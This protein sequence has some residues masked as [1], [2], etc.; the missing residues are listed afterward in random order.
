MNCI[1]SYRALKADAFQIKVYP[2]VLVYKTPAAEYLKRTPCHPITGILENSLCDILRD[3]SRDTSRRGRAL[4][5]DIQ[6]KTTKTIKCK[7][8]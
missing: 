8:N 5:K 1:I 4:F 2:L 7:I 6:V 3:A